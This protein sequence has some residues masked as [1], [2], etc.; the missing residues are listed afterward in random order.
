M[1]DPLAARIVAVPTPDGTMKTLLR[2]LPGAPRP[3]LVLFHDGPGIRPAVEEIAE[4]M[5]R[6]G[7]LVVVPD[8]YHRLG[9]FP[10]FGGPPGTDG[11]TE[12][13]AAIRSAAEGPLADDT[14]ALLETLRGEHWDGSEAACIGFC[15]G[16]VGV[17]RAMSLLGGPFVSGAMF[18]P[19]WCVKEST[20][21]PH[22]SVG[23]IPGQLHVAIGGADKVSP[24]ETNLPLVEELNGM[25]SRASIAVHPGAGHGFMM[26]D[27]HFDPVAA[28]RSWAA[29][30]DLLRTI[31]GLDR[32]P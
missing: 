7:F 26:S 29:T 19:T 27:G 24:L 17:V 1:S 3:L 30:E 8:L 31:P 15:V 14:L 4:R 20:D 6:L 21:S 25:G 32:L 13:L 18:H 22:R 11:H 28:R 10:R 2:S 5:A 9:E 12:M 23:S 16:A